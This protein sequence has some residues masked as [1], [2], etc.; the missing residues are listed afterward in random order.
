MSRRA[1]TAPPALADLHA[2]LAERLPPIP[3][4]PLRDEDRRRAPRVLLDVGARVRLGDLTLIGRIRD[5]AAGGVFLETG[6]LVEAGERG[7]LTLAADVE[8]DEVV[9]VRIAWVRGGAHP[10]GPGLGLAFE[11]FDL[12]AERQALEMLLHLLDLA[13]RR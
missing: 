3:I 5:I 13:E 11:T 6:L 1:G 8:E 12:G 10:Y 9:P 4:V 2:A 7:A